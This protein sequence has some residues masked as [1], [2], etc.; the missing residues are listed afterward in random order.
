[1]VGCKPG[2]PEKE[3]S[4]SAWGSVCFVCYLERYLNRLFFWGEYSGEIQNTS[5][6]SAGFLEK[7]YQSSPFSPFE[8][9][10]GALATLLA[11]L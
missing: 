2:D 7:S 4:P 9:A 10:K 1:M 8:K 3:V 5:Q 11:Q 6:K